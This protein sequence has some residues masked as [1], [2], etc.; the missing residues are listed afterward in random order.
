[1]P[2]AA[3]LG[4]AQRLAEKNLAPHAVRLAS[5]PA[6]DSSQLVFFDIAGVERIGPEIRAIFRI[7]DMQ[8]HHVAFNS[9]KCHDKSANTN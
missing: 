9:H 8:L 6:L 7:F 4:K 3:V 1:M 2:E 5:K